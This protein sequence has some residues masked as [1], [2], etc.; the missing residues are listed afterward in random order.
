MTC[1]RRV[2]IFLIFVCG[3]EICT[4]TSNNYETGKM[5]IKQNKKNQHCYRVNRAFIYILENST[6]S[7]G[8][9]MVF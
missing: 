5:N 1:R 8:N 9:D 4:N 2:V 3:I 6:I 7:L